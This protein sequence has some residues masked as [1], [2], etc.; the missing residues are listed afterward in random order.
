MMLGE[1][2]VFSLVVRVPIT[3]SPEKFNGVLLSESALLTKR[4]SQETFSYCTT[5]GSDKRG[6]TGGAHYHVTLKSDTIHAY[7]YGPDNGLAKDG[8]G[9]KIPH[10]LVK[11]GAENDRDSEVEVKS[12]YRQSSPNPIGAYVETYQI[13]SPG[14]RKE[15]EG[16]YGEIFVD[17]RLFFAI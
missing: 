16:T 15:L 13:V 10:S 12:F 3:L 7:L 4:G 11:L 2:G 6:K 5:N 17:I 8:G 1:N 9:V 14:I